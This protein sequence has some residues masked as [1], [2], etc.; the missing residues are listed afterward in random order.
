MIA[1]LTKV[2]IAHTI[3][4]IC[5]IMIKKLGSIH[6]KGRE[7]LKDYNEKNQETTDAIVTSYK[8]GINQ[9]V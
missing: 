1:A 6:N 4:D 2:T 9:A 3:D 7:A 5:D 8:K